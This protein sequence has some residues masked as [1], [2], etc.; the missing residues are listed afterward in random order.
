MTI[1]NTF[2][3]FLKKRYWIE[4]QGYLGCLLEHLESSGTKIVMLGPIVRQ[5]SMVQFREANKDLARPYCTPVKHGTI[6]GS[7]Q[8]CC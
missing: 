4:K 8:R 7:K 6:Q 1:L 3:Q 2:R 5:L